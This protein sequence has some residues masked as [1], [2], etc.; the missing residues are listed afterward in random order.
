MHTYIHKHVHIYLFTYSN[1]YTYIYIHTLTDLSRRQRR[2]PSSF[3]SSSAPHSSRRISRVTLRSC[4]APPRLARTRMP[5][6]PCRWEREFVTG[7]SAKT[8]HCP[9]SF[10]VFVYIY[11]HIWEGSGHGGGCCEGVRYG[12]LSQD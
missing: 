1:I 2:L 8:R 7:H 11:I 6:S 10:V 4:P 5:H 9:P 12:L 3:S